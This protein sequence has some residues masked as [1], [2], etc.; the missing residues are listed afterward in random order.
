MSPREAIEFQIQAYRQM[1]G[2]ERLA[3]ALRMHDLSC[4][5]AREGI[6]R[7]YPGASE[8]QVNELLRARLQLAVRS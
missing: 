6:R 7:Q 8:A 2:E 5:V 4:D 1:T 3:I